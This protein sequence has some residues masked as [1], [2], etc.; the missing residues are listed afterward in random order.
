[1]AASETVSHGFQGHVM[2]GAVGRSTAPY[3]CCQQSNKVRDLA[4]GCGSVLR[5]KSEEYQMHIGYSRTSTADQIAGLE[6]Q[7]TALVDTGCI[8][9]G[10]G[11]SR[12]FGA[13][14]MR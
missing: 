5:M 1:V 3:F 9:P 13:G 8:L 2:Q 14:V 10:S 12:N 4:G 7:Q 11:I 6:A